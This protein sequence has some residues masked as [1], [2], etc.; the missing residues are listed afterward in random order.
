MSFA[1]FKKQFNKT[2][3][4]LNEKVGGGKGSEKDEEYKA[5]EKKSD[6]IE[7]CVDH[8]HKKTVEYLQPN[9]TARAKLAMQGSYQ[10][11]RGQARNV[12]Y[13][14]PESLLGE[15]FK[16]GSV[17]L[18]DDSPYC[19]SLRAC[20]DAFEQM[21]E[22][23][24]TLEENVKQNFLDPIYQLHQKD[25]KEISQHRK[26]LESRRLD[27]DYKKS[28]GAKVPPEELQTAQDKFEESQDLCYSSMMNLID[29]DVEHIGQLHCFAEAVRDYHRQCADAVDNLVDQL[30]AKMSDAA[31]RP[32]EDR[33]FI[34][35]PKFDS[36]SGSG[37]GDSQSRNSYDISSPVMPQAPA[38]PPKPAPAPS[39]VQ[40]PHCKA[41]YDFE[42]ENEGELEFREEDII[43]LK[44]RIDENWLE[45]EVHGRSGYFPENYVE[46]I[47]PL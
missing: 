44:S 18:D 5:L 23:K 26:K 31:S 41:L 29:S 7:T 22:Y 27:F 36:D 11:A 16:K 30:A 38:A 39:A 42:P 19:E 32:K 2:S 12:R 9:P 45:G 37:G 3:Q 13:P 21:S 20:G 33:S 14:Q 47:I 34:S 43:T 17:D 6:A 8:L 4:Y 25:F 1:G 46:I 24:D 35:R 10:K 15:V 40:G 28:K